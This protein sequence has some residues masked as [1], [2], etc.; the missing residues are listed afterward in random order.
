MTYY[1]S[2]IKRKTIVKG[3][4][5]YKNYSEMRIDALIEK[6]QPKFIINFYEIYCEFR[7][8]SLYKGIY[9][10]FKRSSTRHRGTGL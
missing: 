1:N 10:H 2:E 6:I 7:S 5:L 3:K 4:K 9:F 8:N